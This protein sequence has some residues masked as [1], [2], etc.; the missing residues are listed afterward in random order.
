MICDGYTTEP[1][2]TFDV[3]LSVIVKKYMRVCYSVFLRG[4]DT[5]FTE[6]VYRGKGLFTLRRQR[7]NQSVLSVF[8]CHDSV[9]AI[10]CCHDTHFSCHHWR[11]NWVQ[12]P[13]YCNTEFW[14]KRTR[15]FCHCRH[16]VN[17]SQPE[18]CLILHNGR[19]QHKI[20]WILLSTNLVTT[21]H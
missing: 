10:T 4:E 16:S 15:P 5:C 17:E 21:K 9:N 18:Q 13:F 1:N 11:H 14:R 7:Q 3:K 2:E 6:A 19:K 12:N 8:R 20:N